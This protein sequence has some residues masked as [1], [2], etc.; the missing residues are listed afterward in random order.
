MIGLCDLGFAD[1]ADLAVFSD[2]E[3]YPKQRR[4]TDQ[5]H[6]KYDPTGLG[7]FSFKSRNYLSA[8]IGAIVMPVGIILRML[9]PVR[10]PV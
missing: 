4:N 7:Y 9:L 10:L 3:A 5:Q 6:R 2:A 1:R 8:A